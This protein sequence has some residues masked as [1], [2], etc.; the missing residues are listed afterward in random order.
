MVFRCVRYCLLA[1]L[2]SWS[3]LVTAAPN[4][5]EEQQQLF[6]QSL[7]DFSRAAGTL[8]YLYGMPVFELA[9]LEYRQTN[10]LA[11]DNNAPHAVF[12]YFNGGRVSSHETTWITVANPNVLMASAWVYLKGHPYVIYVPPLDEIWYSVQFENAF[13]VND[14]YLS[15]RTIGQQGG[16]YL[17]TDH[18]WQGALPAGIA[19][20]VRV[21]TPTA[22][23]LTRIAATKADERERHLKYER[24]F[25]LIPLDRYLRDPSRAQ[26]YVPVPPTDTPPPIAADTAMRD[27]VDFFRILNHHLRQLDIPVEEEG[28]MAMF[29]A[30][31]F[32]PHVHFDAQKL[33]SQMLAGLAQAARDG[34][35]YVDTMRAAP[36]KP[37]AGGWS[38]PPMNMGQFGRDYLLRA[39]AVY[40]GAGGNIPAES[41][42]PNAFSDA[43]GRLLSGDHDYTITF[44]RDGMP[45]AQSFWSITLMDAS[46]RFMIDNP[47][48]RNFIGSTTDGLQYNADGS[49]TIFISALEP[50][51]PAL[52]A[53]WLPSAP[54]IRLQL[55]MRIYRPTP[56]ALAGKYSAPPILRR[57]RGTATL[58]AGN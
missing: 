8:G 19:G 13:G 1:L 40:G 54:G 5:S 11:K 20:Q 4:W 33:P 27:T 52:R 30:A 35:R 42:Y 49:L 50:A 56:E 44:P 48:H 25:K 37:D 3:A 28:L 15:S 46:T 17:V 10:G 51:D 31:G 58:P 34:F 45:P 23:I 36:M 7:T 55:V 47:I 14:A 38:W 41:M 16:Y 9:V 43:E 2:V 26:D 57:P 39:I 24:H 32:G 21:T 12:G 22:W 6:G 29:D 18:A 53:N